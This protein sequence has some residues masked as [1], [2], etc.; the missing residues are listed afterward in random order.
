MTSLSSRLG[1][2]IAAPRGNEL[3][4][5][6][7]SYVIDL[8][9]KV[10]ELASKLRDAEAQLA[11]SLQPPKTSTN[12]PPQSTAIDTTPCSMPR[13]GSTPRE[14]G[15][16][17]A[18]GQ[19]ESTESADDEINELNHH[20]NAIEFH[21]STSSAAFIGHLQKVREP[22]TVDERQARSADFSLISTLHNPS[23]SPSCTNGPAQLTSIQH[24]NYYFDQ[25]HVFMNGYFENIHFVHPFIDK[26]DFL[27]RANDLWFNRAHTPEPS[28][29]ALY[30]S[31]LS[32]GALVRV[33]DE[34]T[35]GGLGRFEWSRK[36]FSEA[37]SY[38]NYL[39]FSNDLETV[40]CLYL[41]VSDGDFDQVRIRINDSRQKSAKMSS[42]QTVS[43]LHYDI[44][45]HLLM[46]MLISGLHV[47]RTRSAYMP[48]R[49]FQ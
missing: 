49:G 15:R 26:E 34:D 9:K 1:I 37:Q 36:L 42:T 43:P 12:Q 7:S 13:T 19:E 44:D 3:V 5:D 17:A 8:E 25:A 10:E 24:Q 23:F 22:K 46:L 41:M 16:L 18:E 32:F 27:V 48:F 21:G 2:R 39:R 33:W 45:Y 28:F 31:V 38:L 29:V 20:T 40:Q 4:A 47:S 30:L 11:T 35:L 14:V 6:R